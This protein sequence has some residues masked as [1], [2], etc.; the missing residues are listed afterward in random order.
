MVDTAPNIFLWW[1][2]FPLNVCLCDNI[3]RNSFSIGLM[4]CWSGTI[5]C[6][7]CF[8]YIPQ[9]KPREGCYEKWPDA[10]CNVIVPTIQLQNI[11]FVVEGTWC[12]CYLPLTMKK[13]VIWPANG[14]LAF[15]ARDREYK[16]SLILMHLYG[17]LMGPHLGYGWWCKDLP[18]LEAVQ[19]GIMGSI[20]GT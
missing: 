13:Q 10:I 11:P 12:N 14:M 3:T 5:F 8:L 15:N 20:P 19:R 7:C 6:C 17:E 4:Q 18:A 1:V 9:V 2:S 16:C